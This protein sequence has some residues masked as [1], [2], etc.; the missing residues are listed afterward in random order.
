M[1][2][3]INS[4]CQSIEN[5]VPAYKTKNIAIVFETSQFFVPYL[6]VALLSLLQY[7]SPQYNYDILILSCELQE[8]DEIALRNI[9]Q[10][11]DNIIMRFLNPHLIAKKYIDKARF[12]YLEINYYRLLLPWILQN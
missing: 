12:N 5:L 1:I 9:I 11:K 4:E 8:H 7:T 10:G 6:S 2:N 3:L